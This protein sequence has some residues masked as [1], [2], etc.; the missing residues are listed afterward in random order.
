M[1]NATV[2]SRL[3][4]VKEF[5]LLDDMP[6]VDTFNMSMFGLADDDGPGGKGPCGTACCLA[7]GLS[8][9]PV[10]Q[11]RGM[12]GKWRR[13]PSVGGIGTFYWE[14]NCFDENGDWIAFDEAGANVIGTTE[15]EAGEL[16]SPGMFVGGR[17]V[18][19]KKEH[20]AKRIDDLIEKYGG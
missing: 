18:A 5:L 14:L 17:Y 10:W 6:G 2:V 19:A 13:Y 1:D 8:L 12:V 15:E 16:F 20:V 11:E 4:E 7:G 9:Q 3:E